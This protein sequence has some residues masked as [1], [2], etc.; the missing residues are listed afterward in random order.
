M[1]LAPDR[2]P[3]LSI[4]AVLWICLAQLVLPLARAQ[5]GPVAVAVEVSYVLGPGD[6]V[7]LD[8]MGEPEMS[9]DRPVEADGAIQ[10]P[11]AGRVVVGGYTLDGAVEQV[12][13]RLRDG[14]LKNPQ[15]VLTVIQLGSKKVSVSGGVNDQGQFPFTAAA[16][17]VSD[18]LVRAGGLVDT[19]TPKAELWRDVGGVRQVIAVD[20]ERMGAGDKEADLELLPGDH[21]EVPPALQIFVDGH[22]QKPGQLVFREGMT[23]TQAIAAAGGTS[24]TALT[25]KVKVIRGDDQSLLN[26]KRVLKGQD[27][28]VMLRPGDHVYVPESPI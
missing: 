12:S 18:L 2:P 5:E 4:L 9:G 11:T 7:H 6:R 10:V 15:V 16:M 19:S 3:M 27:A 23:V 1:V 24:S 26:L 8:V 28:D 14:Y 13:A 25:T 17:H 21:L 22:V 20:L